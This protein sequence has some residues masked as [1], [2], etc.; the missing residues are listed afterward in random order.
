MG[1]SALFVFTNASPQIC[2]AR[3]G[4]HGTRFL[5]DAIMQRRWNC[6]NDRVTSAMVGHMSFWNTLPRP[7]FVMAPME[8]VTDAA[9]RQMFAVH[10]KPHVTYTEFT[11]A[12]GLV[13]APEPGK[14]KL[15]KKFLFA[16]NERPIV[17]QLFSASPERM[18]A[19]ARL[20]ADM[21]FDGV[22]I[23]MGCP[24]R[25]VEKQGCGA[26][27]IN[28]PELAV[29]LMRAVRRGAPRLPLSVKTRIGYNT[30]E[31][32]RWV[33]QI[34]A[35]EPAALTLHMRTRKEMSDVPAHWERMRDTVAIRDSLGS[36]TL[37]IGNGDV[38]DLADA[39]AK[40]A[41]SGC[42]GIMLGRAIFGNPWLFAEHTPSPKERVAVLSEHLHRFEE[43]LGT[44]THYAVM[45]KHF[46]AYIH[47]WDNAKDLR[48]QLMETNSAAEAQAVLAAHV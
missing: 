29:E 45:K 43:L 27:L 36:K 12:D 9:F 41:E 15:L 22:D 14:T 40:A 2:I 46:K 38:F 8:D 35:E 20:A 6:C 28:N 1:R 16:D 4:T 26:A 21:G 30:D 37:L 34:L 18:E 3:I 25:A 5:P 48:V 17:A 32:E 11:S 31:L 10:G 44:T 13:L 19:A 33:P 39:R 24:D 23:N 42:D 47:G 7:F